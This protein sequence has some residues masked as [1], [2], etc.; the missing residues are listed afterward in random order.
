MVVTVTVGKSDLLKIKKGMKATVLSLDKEYE[1]EV[2][3]VGA[4][5][6]E[7][8][9]IDINSITSSLMGSSGAGG[10]I[11]KVKI[12][13]PDEKVVLGFDVDIKIDLSKIDDVLTVPVEAVL[14][15][16][17]VYSVYVYNE[18]KGI[19]EKHTIEKGML[20]DKSYQVID[21]LAEGDKVIKSPDPDMPE[22][23]RIKEKTA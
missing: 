18:K 6:N 16:S 3:Y 7:Q 14:Y 23:T 20:D 5:A 8:E 15:N 12:N 17:G 1:G 10:A 2:I 11:V 21:G 22:G 19:A 4:T 9:S 13:A